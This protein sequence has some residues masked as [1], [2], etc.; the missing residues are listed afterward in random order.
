[1]P[2]LSRLVLP[3]MLIGGIFLLL[4]LL[5]GCGGSGGSSTTLTG[6]NLGALSGRVTLPAGTEL[7]LRS[8]AAAAAESI[9]VWLEQIPEKRA[10]CDAQGRYLLEG[11]T[12]DVA[13]NLVARWQNAASGLVFIQ[14]SATLQVEPGKTTEAGD[15]LLELAENRMAAVIRDLYGNPIANARFTLWGIAG[16]T[17]L[18]GRFTT[19]ALPVSVKSVF[20]II[21][22]SGFTPLT[23]EFPVFSSNLGPLLEINLATLQDARRTPLVLFQPVVTTVEPGNTIDLVLTIIDPDLLLPANYT[24][25]WSSTDGTLIVAA[26]S[27]SASWQAPDEAGLASITVAI[28]TAGFDSQASLGFAV[29]GSYQINTRVT[30]F[31]PSSAAA[32]Q[33][34]IIK[35]Y[36][37]GATASSARV[38]FAG[39]PGTIATWAPEEIRAIVPVSAE[40]GPLVVEI[41]NKTLNAGNFTVIDYAATISPNYGPPGVVVAIEGYGFGDEQGESR[42]TLRGDELPVLKWTNT[43]VEAQI[44]NNSHSGTVALTIRGR[45]RP[46]ADYVVTRISAIDPDRTTRLNEGSASVLSISGIG[47]GENQ[48]DSEV[49]FH[50][51]QPGEVVGWSD[52]EIEVEIPFAAVSG[53]LVVR[54]NGADVITPRLN[55]VYHDTYT[56]EMSWSGPRLESL[57]ELPGIAITG[58]GEL[59]VTDYSNGWV[60]R[61]SSEG[62]FIERIGSPGYGNGQFNLPW[63]IT[64]DSEDNIFIA[65]A[66]DSGGR[67]QK[68]DSAG[69]FVASLNVGGSAPGQLNSPLGI[70]MDFLGNL[71]VADSGNH[72]IQKFNN[73][74]QFLD[75]WGSNGTDDG[76]FDLP[77]A[78]AVAPDGKIYVADLG[79][80]RIQEFAGDG[81]F[82]RWYGRDQ[83]DGTGWK[84]AG[85]GLNGREGQKPGQFDEPAGIFVAIDG[86]LFV[87]DTE[88]GRIQKIDRQTGTAVVIGEQGRGDGQFTEPVS[89]LMHASNLYIADSNNSRIQVVSPEGEFRQKIVPDTSDLNTFFTRLAVDRQNELVYA[90]DRDDGSIAVFDL[91]GNFI[92]RIGSRGSGRGQLLDPAGLTVDA[93]GNILVADTGNARVVM[94]SPEGVLL[95]SFGAYGTGPGQFRSPQR[96]A[97]GA[98]ESIM[99]SDFDNH[100]IV[101]FS[102]TGDYLYAFGSP[103]TGNGQFN[104][105]LGISAAS[106]GSIYVADSGNARVQKFSAAGVFLGWFGADEADNAG[107]HGVSTSSRGAKDTGPCRFQTP[108]DLAIDREDCVYVLDGE[109][110]EIQKF[111]PDHTREINAHHVTTLVSLEGFVGLGLDEIGN[112]YTTE[113]DQTIKRLNPSLSP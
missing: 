72:R 87:S 105:P 14:R 42:V 97:L 108:T 48:G 93:E 60:W 5:P 19:P 113:K 32:G 44:L 110:G 91:F 24:V 4:A 23:A 65:D 83:L 49:F 7:Q 70:C 98:D 101:V 10:L 85:S 25:N 104:G 43:R 6:S 96:I 61:F 12:P 22:A 57:P 79:N 92:Q 99:V 28:S 66:P 58:S 8:A 81:T 52:S 29:G 82:L 13:Y 50:D 59:L 53:D 75:E 45:L 94:F 9:E 111:G 74:L 55:L 88:N 18:Q 3:V 67:I 106:D 54:I 73:Q 41:G 47:F 40:S 78:V 107:W 112:L 31:S 39:T 17:D 77:A 51:E 63:G 90:L 2:A 16:I 11:L 109:A 15:T 100:R 1:M 35:G 64:V 36:G 71:F 76:Q 56:V 68:L 103:G 102:P 27:R 80:H 38:L 84:N 20:L 89:L 26:N 33:T 30:S 95:M 21:E 46:V 62:D 34:V 86:S 37:F 69:N